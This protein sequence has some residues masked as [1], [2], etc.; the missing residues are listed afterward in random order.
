M[1]DRVVICCSSCIIRLP[2]SINEK[3]KTYTGMRNGESGC[4]GTSRPL[5]HIVGTPMCMPTLSMKVVLMSIKF[6]K[7]GLQENI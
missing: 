6:S 3:E 1:A 5:A 7:M 4:D 2:F